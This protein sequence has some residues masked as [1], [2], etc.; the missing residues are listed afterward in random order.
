MNNATSMAPF[1][2]NVPP[3]HVA[4][5]SA[6]FKASWR[7]P[8]TCPTVKAVY[9]IVGTQAS[10]NQYKRYRAATE[11]RGNFVAA[12]R[13]A[14]NE[15]RR[16][17]GT[18][19]KCLVGD[20]GHKDPCSSPACSLCCILKTSY[21]LNLFGKKTGWGR[22][23]SGIYTSSTSSKSND[24]SRNEIKSPWK[25][26][27]LNRVVV[28]K[29]YKLKQDDPTLTSPPAG[30]DSVLGETGGSLNHD[31][32]IVYSNDAIRPSWLIMYAP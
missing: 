3:D 28:G 32:L 16:W 9:K 13:T 29:G 6:Q 14:G 23:G 8:S 26:V 17:H 20:S 31:E 24:Y 12:R 22:F 7:H 18:T 11:A 21:N 15:C 1:I 27:M 10:M 4:F 30:Y 25:A 2:L 19:R 5:E